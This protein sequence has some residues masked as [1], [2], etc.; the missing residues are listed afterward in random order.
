VQSR[1]AEIVRPPDVVFQP[2]PR[3]ALCRITKTW[4]EK[5]T[6]P[7]LAKLAAGSKLGELERLL[8]PATFKARKGLPAEQR[9]QQAA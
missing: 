8:E 7:E 4:I 1:D 2:A 3:T 5:S 9:P 6:F